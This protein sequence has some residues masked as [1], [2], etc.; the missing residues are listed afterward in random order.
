VTTTR[1][2]ATSKLSLTGKQRSYLRALAHPLKPLVQ[3][4]HAGVTAPVVGQIDAALET[5]ELIKVRILGEDVDTRG[6]A[7]AIEQGTRSIVAQIIG[8]TLVVYR[9]RQKDP[10]IS[11]PKAG[12]SSPRD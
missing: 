1:S 9:R 5:H 11:L 7:E 10:V 8:K 2:A 3:V 6:M 12:R 4:G